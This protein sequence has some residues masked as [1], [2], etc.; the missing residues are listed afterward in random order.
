MSKSEETESKHTQ[1]TKTGQFI[2]V[3]YIN[4]NSNNCSFKGINEGSFD[5]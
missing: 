4:N 5:R 1:N 2:S 3:E